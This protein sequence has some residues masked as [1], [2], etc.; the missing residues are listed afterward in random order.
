MLVLAMQFSRGSRCAEKPPPQGRGL[1]ERTFR[2]EQRTER[3]EPAD[4]REETPAIDDRNDSDP[5]STCFNLGIL[6][7]IWVEMTP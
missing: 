2:T 5:T 3:L 4:Q 7:H 6:N 1:Q